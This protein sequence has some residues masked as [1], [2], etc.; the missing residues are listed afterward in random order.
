RRSLRSHGAMLA[1]ALLL[2]VALPAPVADAQPRILDLPQAPSGHVTVLVLD[3]S[4]S[5][6]DTDPNGLR[7]SAANAYIDLS[8]PGNLIGVVGL[9]NAGQ[10]G[11][12]HNFGPAQ[13]WAQP[14]E[15]A[16]VADRQRL[17]DTI[18]TKSNNCTPDQSTPTYDALNQAL[19][20]LTRATSDGK[21]D[22]SVI[23][24]TDGAPQ[25]DSDNQIA[26]IKSE[27]VPQLKQHSFP[28]DTVALGA[29]NSSNPFH[30]F[31]N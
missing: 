22:G 7:C 5:M 13:V 31:L 17:K 25:P 4:G 29:D 1:L 9:D 19:Q 18:K 6:A 8:G 10:S 11:G 30:P 24:L 26:T 2:L 12:P 15:M 21:H 28:V 3:M 14:A 27:L 16:T 23:L 20:M